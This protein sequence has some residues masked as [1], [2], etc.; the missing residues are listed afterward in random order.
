MGSALCL[1]GFGSD[2]AIHTVFDTSMYLV[3]TGE[4]QFEKR[5]N[6][7]PIDVSVDGGC[8]RISMSIV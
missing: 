7:M 4:N 2:A 5:S 8:C 1:Y 6:L 3:E